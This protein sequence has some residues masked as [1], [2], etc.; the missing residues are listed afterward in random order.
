MNARTSHIIEYSV[1]AIFIHNVL[2]ESV[3]EM[4]QIVKPAL[5]ALLLTFLL[6]TFDESIQI[7]LPNRVFDVND[8]AFNSLAGLMAIGSSVVLN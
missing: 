1:L 5:I 3:N 7:I 4:R 6:G 2:I 8:I